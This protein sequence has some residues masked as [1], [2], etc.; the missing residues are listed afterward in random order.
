VIEQ[1]AQDDEN[2][3][4][5]AFK[6]CNDKSLADDIVNDMYLTMHDKCK[7]KYSEISI[8][9]VWSVMRNIYLKHIKL[10]K[11]TISLEEFHNI[12]D[13]RI[14]NDVLEDRIIINDALNELSLW[15]REVLLHTSERSLRELSKATGISVS[16]LHYGKHNALKKLKDKL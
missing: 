1:L 9:Y 11:K 5:I 7:R 13:L 12:E 6:I 8:S 16:V 14:D 10:N 2:W 4:R 3:R 15:D